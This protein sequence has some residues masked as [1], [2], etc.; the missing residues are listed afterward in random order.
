MEWLIAFAVGALTGCLLWPLARAAAQLRSLPLWVREALATARFKRTFGIAPSRDQD[1]KAMLQPVVG[2]HVH[3][4][5][6]RALRTANELDR[7]RAAQPPSLVN[8]RRAVAALLKAKARKTEAERRLAVAMQTASL[9]GFTLA[10]PVE[11][12]DAAQPKEGAAIQRAPTMTTDAKTDHVTLPPIA[13]PVP[14]LVL[15]GAGA[16]NGTGNGQT[17]TRAG[18]DHQ[19]AP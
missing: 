14:L 13:S 5:H 15:G 11:R 2:Q 6:E 10:V 7:F 12:G 3:Q 8:A 17:A 4:L 1:V 18:G 19:Q 9:W 16:E